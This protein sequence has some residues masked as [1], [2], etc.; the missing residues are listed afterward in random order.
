VQWKG[1]EKGTRDLVVARCGTLKLT[2]ASSEGAFIE[3]SINFFKKPRLARFV[4]MFIKR[5]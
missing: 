2:C 1:T 4:G 5:N 3:P